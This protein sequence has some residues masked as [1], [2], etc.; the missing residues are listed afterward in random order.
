M[1]LKIY[2]S[3]Y[4]LPFKDNYLSLPKF[5]ITD[6]SD[7]ILSSLCGIIWSINIIKI[8]SSECSIKFIVK[9]ENV[10]L[11]YSKILFHL[12]DITNMSFF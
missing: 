10:S 2:L 9:Q 7:E 12:I 3:R 1:I 4:I 11:I 8:I 5:C 6:I